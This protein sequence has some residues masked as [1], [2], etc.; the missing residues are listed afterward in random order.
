MRTGECPQ[1]KRKTIERYVPFLW[2]KL[3]GKQGETGGETGKNC[4]G[5]WISAAAA[6]S[7]TARCNLFQRAVKFVSA[8]AENPN[9]CLLCFFA[10]L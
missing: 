5:L 3:P 2:E 1:T 9:S 10:A 7:F 8:G 6:I 4:R